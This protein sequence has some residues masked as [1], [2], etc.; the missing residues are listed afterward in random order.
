[1]THRP[2]IRRNSISGVFGL[3]QFFFAT[4]ASLE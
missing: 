4:S 1:L 2:M 3:E